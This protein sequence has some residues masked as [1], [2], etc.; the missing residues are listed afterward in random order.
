MPQ[1]S[2]PLATIKRSL[3][4]VERALDRTS[5]SLTSK[6]IVAKSG[7]RE[8]E[9]NEFPQLVA[10][11]EQV[12]EKFATLTDKTANLTRSLNRVS[13]ANATPAAPATP[14]ISPD[15]CH[16]HFSGYNWRRPRWRRL[17][18]WWRWTGRRST[19]SNLYYQHFPNQRLHYLS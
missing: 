8:W 1:F 14:V 16:H 13:G 7:S 19:G 10:E 2:D 18:W 9:E 12:Q 11:L 3:E 6:G 15:S 5:I 4:T 17:F